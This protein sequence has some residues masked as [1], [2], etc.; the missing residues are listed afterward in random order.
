ML[1]QSRLS[2]L[3]VL[4][5]QLLSSSVCMIIQLRTLV[6][7]FWVSFLDMR[8]LSFAPRLHIFRLAQTAG[9][10][11]SGHQSGD[12]PWSCETCHHECPGCG[13]KCI[14]PAQWG[15]ASAR[16]PAHLHVQPHRPALECQC[17]CSE[18]LGAPQ[19]RCDPGVL[20]SYQGLLINITYIKSGWPVVQRHLDP[21]TALCVLFVFQLSCLRSSMS[22]NC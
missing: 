7:L 9:T 11:S 19:Q 16:H 3:A 1:Q 15:H 14:R 12:I 6:S 8:L 17:T 18:S 21:R 10:V 2:S 22:R 20:L 5:E 13:P 4:A